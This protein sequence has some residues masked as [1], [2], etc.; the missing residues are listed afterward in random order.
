MRAFTS[1]T[2]LLTLGSINLEHND[3][4]MNLQHNTKKYK[5][6]KTT[7]KKQHPSGVVVKKTTAHSMLCKMMSVRFGLTNELKLKWNLYILC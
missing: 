2:Q 1:L 7:Q 6:K 5:T 3:Y 4:P